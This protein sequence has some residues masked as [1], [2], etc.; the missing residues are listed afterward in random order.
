MIRG[1][2]LC[3][4]I[5]YEISGGLHDMHFCHCSMC[6]KA[7]GTAFAAYAGLDP[8]DLRFTQGEE[9]ISR[10]QSSESA[11]RSFCRRCGSNLTFEPTATPDE[12][13]MAAGGFDS[14][15]QERPA[16]HIYVASKASW[17]EITDAMKQYPEEN[18]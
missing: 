4:G 12:I 17:F 1:S 2:C 7:H 3:G 16:F 14:E 11:Q 10:Y 9:L 5:H 15:P 13:W 18:D 6:R 8:R